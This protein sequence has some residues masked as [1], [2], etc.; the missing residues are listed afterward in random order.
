MPSL[1]LPSVLTS[2]NLIIVTYAH[3]CG[4]HFVPLIIT[5]VLI[6]HTKENS[7]PFYGVPITRTQLRKPLFREFLDQKNY[8][9]AEP[10]TKTLLSTINFCSIFVVIIAHSC[11]NL[12]AVAPS[13]ALFTYSM[14]ICNW[15]LIYDLPLVAHSCRPCFIS[16]NAPSCKFEFS[17]LAHSCAPL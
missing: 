15:K 5:H 2:F 12:I 4:I 17:F 3:S 6:T 10:Q 8:A 7:L 16:F 1:T 9:F 14:P 13:C 11:K